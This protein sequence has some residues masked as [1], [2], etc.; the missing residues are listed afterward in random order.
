MEVLEQE[1]VDVIEHHAGQ[2]EM[3]LVALQEIQSRAGY[4]SST[5]CVSLAKALGVAEGELQ[6]V[7]SFYSDLRTSPPGV[8]RVCVCH[9]DSCTA[10]GSHHI[11][12]TVEALL[13]ITPNQTTSDGQITY[14]RVFCLG[15]CALSPSISIDE[16]VYGHS[17]PEGVE[18]RLKRL[19]GTTDG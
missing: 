2:P 11:A 4:I 6:G 18:K 16:Y 3:A 14:E 8:H 9:G 15:N 7:I 19:K 17:N 10:M 12:D 5:T 13:G 1:I